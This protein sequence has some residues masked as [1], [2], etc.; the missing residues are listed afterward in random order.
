MP[1]LRLGASRTETCANAGA[2][3]TNLE[4]YASARRKT[5]AAAQRAPVNRAA[6]EDRD[7]VEKCIFVSVRERAGGGGAGDLVA[8]GLEL[9]CGV[10]LP[11]AFRHV[12]RRTVIQ[13]PPATVSLVTKQQS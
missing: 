12:A 8:F 10:R 5:H 9:G 6:S 1:R 7:D 13:T 3:E 2:R 11:D 4:R